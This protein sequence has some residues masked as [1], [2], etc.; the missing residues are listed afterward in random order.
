MSSWDAQTADRLSRESTTS[1]S[2]R[3]M[4]DLFPQK[5]LPF[6]F[7]NWLHNPV[8]D[9]SLPFKVLREIEKMCS[10]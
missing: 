1:E 7:E 9:F 2:D 8:E 6:S 5:E 10:C 3:K 4:L